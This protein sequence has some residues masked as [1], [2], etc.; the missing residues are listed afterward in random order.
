MSRLARTSAKTLLAAADLFLPR[1]KGPRVLIYHQVGTELGRE[2]EVTNRDFVAQLDW[3][4]AHGEVVDLETAMSQRNTD[5]ADRSFV[6]TFDDGYR[7]VYDV[8]WPHLRKRRLPFLLYLTTHPV[9]TQEPL[10]DRR[11]LPLTWTQ[12]EE[13]A[14]SGL[15]TLGAHTHTHPDLRRLSAEEVEAELEACDRLIADR[16]SIRP[17]HFAYPWGY[18]SS[19]ADPVVRRRYATAAL[20]APITSAP[21]VDDHL[22]PRLPVQ[23]S[24]GQAFFRIRMRTGLRVEEMARRRL[25]GY[26]QV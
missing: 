25:R 20:G 26:A 18:W 11:A 17:R 12:L 14:A 23:R 8:A 9:E 2:M 24:D 6:L 19:V 5:S 10:S 15:L 4:S 22:V 16:T 1:L 13:M 7:D 3:I 21:F